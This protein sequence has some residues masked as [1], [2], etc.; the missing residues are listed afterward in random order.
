MKRKQARKKTTRKKKESKKKWCYGTFNC[1]LRSIQYA[2]LIPIFLYYPLWLADCCTNKRWAVDKDFTWDKKRYSFL[3]LASHRYDTI[4]KFIFQKYF[5][6]KKVKFLEW[7]FE[8]VWSSTLN[9]NISG[10]IIPHALQLRVNQHWH[11]INYST[12]W[13]PQMF[14]SE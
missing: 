4:I 3:L 7:F 14:I 10:K 9:W 13:L 1:F 2:N 6:R 11:K 5:M 8:K 12:G